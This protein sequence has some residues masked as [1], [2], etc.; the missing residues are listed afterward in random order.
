M[1]AR[2]L[3]VDDN[4]SL[5]ENLRDVLEGASGLGAR[6]SAV[7]SGLDAERVARERGFDVALVDVKLPDV[8]GVQ[9]VRA[10]RAAAPLS[11]VVLI[12]GFAT[13]DSA[14]AA[15]QAGAFAFLLKSYRP[16]EL[17]STVEQ[18]VAKVQ[19]KR[20]RQ[21]LERRQR[22]LIDTAGVLIMAVDRA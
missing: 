14:I 19:L 11:E 20:E 2:I 10:L 4:A 9:L 17:I 7:A 15:L 6:V 1:T 22:A 3:I 8:N 21:E 5:A 18:A 13:V 12:T 16:E